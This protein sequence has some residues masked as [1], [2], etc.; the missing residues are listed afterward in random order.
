MTRITTRMVPISY[1]RRKHASNFSLLL[2]EM[3]VSLS[4]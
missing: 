2:D 1:L 4:W 3:P